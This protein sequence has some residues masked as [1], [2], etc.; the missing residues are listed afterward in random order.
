MDAP[1][2]SM[3]IAVTL[4][5]SDSIVLVALG[6]HIFPVLFAMVLFDVPL[7]GYGVGDRRPERNS[8]AESKEKVEKW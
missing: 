4:V 2:V 6:K 8:S 7:H 3:I 5:M 1:D